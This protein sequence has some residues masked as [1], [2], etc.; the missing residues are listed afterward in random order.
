M[1]RA[2]LFV[3]ALL[4]AG[5]QAPEPDAAAKA[6]RIDAANRSPSDGIWRLQSLTGFDS[7]PGQM[8][9]ISRTTY[10]LRGCGE[11]TG[12]LPTRENPAV[13]KTSG[14][15]P[16]CD[17]RDVAVQRA[18]LALFAAE[19]TVDR[20]DCGADEDCPYKIVVRSE[21]ATATFHPQFLN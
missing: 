1:R 8:L 21:G 3:M 15:Q 17:D 6:T 9:S 11:A 2:A 19:P 5:C 12:H 20:Q 16:T 18:L 14:A 10:S 4:A 13:M 7:V